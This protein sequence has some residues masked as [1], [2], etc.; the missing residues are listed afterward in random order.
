MKFSDHLAMHIKSRGLENVN[1]WESG[2]FYRWSSV[3]HIFEHILKEKDA[4]LAQICNAPDG[5]DDHQLK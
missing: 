5:N 3:K 1:G 4:E 2:F